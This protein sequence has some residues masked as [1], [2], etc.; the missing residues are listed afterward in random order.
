MVKWLNKLLAVAISVSFFISATEMNI[1]EA[2]NTFF[3]QYDTY[4][5]TEQ[6]SID[7]VQVK[8]EQQ[9]LYQIPALLLSYYH[10]FRKKTL[11]PKDTD[12]A[13]GASPPKLFLRNSVWR[14]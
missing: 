12:I 2:E 3:D 1:G 14:I 10:L 13:F 5:K 4:L 8:Q 6:V 7:H 11:Y 9:E